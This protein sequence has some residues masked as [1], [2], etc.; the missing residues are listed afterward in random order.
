METSK[1]VKLE[2]LLGTEDRSD[3]APLVR[4]I[5]EAGK[6]AGLSGMT[7]TKAVAGF[8]RSGAVHKAAIADF[9]ESLPLL[10]EC[11]DQ[12]EKVVAFVKKNKPL[13]ENLRIALIDVKLAVL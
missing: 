3:G 13:L 2:I 1:A 4:K 11:I 10:V 7:V 5:L 8:G 6:E 12:E 9:S